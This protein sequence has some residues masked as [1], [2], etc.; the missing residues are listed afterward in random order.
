MDMAIIIKQH[1]MD[2]TSG[3]WIGGIFGQIHSAICL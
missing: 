1:H 3:Y 2:D